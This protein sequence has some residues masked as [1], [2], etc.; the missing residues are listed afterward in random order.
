MFDLSFIS[1]QSVKGD[2][3][4]ISEYNLGKKCWELSIIEPQNYLTKSS[5]PKGDSSLIA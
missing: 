1:N 5:R 3:M 4:D 2:E